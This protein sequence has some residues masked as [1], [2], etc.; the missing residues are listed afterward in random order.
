MVPHPIRLRH[1]WES[2]PLAT[3]QI[4]YRRRFNRPTGLELH[5]QVALEI[6]R[7]MVAADVSLN[8]HPLGQIK[9]AEFF[10][11]DITELLAA[12]NELTILADPLTALSAPPPS[13]SIYIADPDALP[14]S[15]VGEV[16]LVI[17]SAPTS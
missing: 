6:D 14:G 15:P 3:G 16:R 11:A 5:E 7:T 12:A 9:P 10:S 13:Q 17:R 4:L 8:G 1:P 2:Q